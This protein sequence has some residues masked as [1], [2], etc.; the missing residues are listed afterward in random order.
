MAGSI[1]RN[2]AVMLA[3]ALLVSVGA[4]ADHSAIRRQQQQRSRRGLRMC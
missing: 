2:G 4:V 1:H 3:V